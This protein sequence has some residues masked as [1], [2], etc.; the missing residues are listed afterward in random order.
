MYLAR[1]DL[2]S[3]AV[4]G[5]GD[6]GLGLSPTMTDGAMAFHLTDDAQRGLPLY[7][8]DVQVYM[9]WWNGTVAEP[10]PTA[11]RDRLVA[12]GDGDDTLDWVFK[13]IKDMASIVVL[14]CDGIVTEPNIATNQFSIQSLGRSILA[15]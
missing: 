5:G 9:N 1:N 12:G 13:A 15:G 3:H 10:D 4:M 14:Y 7:L 6:L 11:Q 8:P 2:N